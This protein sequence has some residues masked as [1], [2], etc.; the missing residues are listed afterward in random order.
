MYNKINNKIFVAFEL[1]ITN[2]Y[3]KPWSLWNKFDIQNITSCFIKVKMMYWSPY[4]EKI[5]SFLKRW[6][7]SKYIKQ[8]KN[9]RSL[10]IW[11]VLKT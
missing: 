1:Q 6:E 7:L 8:K 4:F 11:E 9:K 3:N 10:G 2:V 5:Y